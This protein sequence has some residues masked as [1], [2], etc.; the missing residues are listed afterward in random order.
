MLSYT[1]ASQIAVAVSGGADSMALAILLKGWCDKNKI[2]LTA[3]TVDHGLR[4]ESASE[5]ETV[6]AWMKNL[7]IR[8]VVLKLK[9]LPE[10]RIQENARINRYQI[11]AEYCRRNGITH[12][13]TAHHLDDQFETLIMRMARG[14]GLKGLCGIQK[15]R[16]MDGVLLVRPVLDFAKSDLIEICENNNQDW[17]RDPSNKDLKYDR[18]QI[19]EH[20]KVLDNIG[21][22]AKMLEK[23]RYKLSGAANFILSELE[24]ANSK[25]ITRSNEKAAV[26]YDEFLKLHPYLQKEMLESLLKEYGDNAYPPKSASLENLLKKIQ[27]RSFNG[28]TLHNCIV[29]VSGR[30]LVIRPEK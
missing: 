17:V 6:S 9:D 10:T 18:V 20:S 22:T 19:R 28:A 12:L 25:I 26:D 30:D 23:T 21:L 7:D 13:L 3:I 8:H 14:S 16:Q 5:A 29:S 11:M 15:E 27:G 4:A 24:K 2:D 1:D